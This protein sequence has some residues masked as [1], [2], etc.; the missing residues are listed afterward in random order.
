M[1]SSSD[2]LAYGGSATA[3]VWKTIAELFPDFDGTG[4]LVITQLG[5]RVGGDTP[6]GLKNL[7]MAR[8][9][10][11]GFEIGRVNLMPEY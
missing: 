4:E 7:V 5:G 9:R 1:M 10:W 2:M 3:K 8:L 11:I 6:S